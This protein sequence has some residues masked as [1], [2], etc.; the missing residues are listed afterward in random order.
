VIIFPEGAS[1]S[2]VEK[3]LMALSGKIWPRIRVFFS[4]S[5]VSLIKVRYAA[6]PPHL[7]A[8]HEVMSAL[9]GKTYP[10]KEETTS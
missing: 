9:C 2:A 6:Y 5:H 3:E 7:V 8:L 1:R 10:Q 4:T